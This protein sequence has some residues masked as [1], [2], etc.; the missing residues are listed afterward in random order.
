M[1]ITH[2]TH[3]WAP[4]VPEHIQHYLAGNFADF[5]DY[6]PSITSVTQYANERTLSWA[7]RSVLVDVLQKQYAAISG[8]Q[9]WVLDNIQRLWQT[10]S[11]TITTGQQ[12]HVLWGPLFFMTKIMDAIALA[13]QMNEK[14]DGKR[15]IPVFWLAI[16][17]HDF[18]EINHVDVYGERFFR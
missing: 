18:D 15:Y 6:A 14:N 5:V 3:I 9:K 2:L 10:N 16:E 11:F 12:I 17:D 8:E 4:W 1:N 7:K 13:K